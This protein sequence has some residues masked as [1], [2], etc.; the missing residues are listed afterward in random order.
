M[1][2]TPR[3]PLL[4]TGIYLVADWRSGVIQYANAGHP[5]PLHVRRRAGSVVP[6]ANASGKSQPALGL[7]EQA[8]YQA[9]EALLLPDD[10]LVLFTDGLIEV[11]NETGELYSS[12]L[13]AAEVASR[14]NQPTCQLFDNLLDQ[15]RCFAGGAP[16]PDDVCM[17][18][19]DFLGDSDRF[20]NR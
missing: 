14:C 16:F 19:L 2:A 1:S 15:I 13:L 4:T 10:L 20:L 8:S 17:V 5:K 9:S 18:G 11:Q 6:L 7:I 12:P 3:A